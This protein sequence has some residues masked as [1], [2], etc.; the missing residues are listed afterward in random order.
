MKYAKKQLVFFIIYLI[1]GALIFA[2][3]MLWSPAE[4]RTGILTGIVSGFLVTGVGGIILSARLLK[5]PPKAQQVEIAKTEERTQLIRLKTHSAV[6]YVT[7]LLICVGTFVTEICG[8]WEIT[9]TLAAL[10]IVEVV[11]YVC[12]SVYYTKKY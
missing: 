2:A 1:F 8:Y 10:L 4:K 5:N 3:A 11:L 9:V 12:F 7:V 6:Y